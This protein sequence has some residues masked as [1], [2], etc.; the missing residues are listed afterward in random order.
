MKIRYSKKQFLFNGLLGGTF[1]L[2]SLIQLFRKEESFSAHHV[3][4]GIQFLLGFT[5]V[6]L[7]FFQRKFQYLNIENG[8][9]TKN[10]LR[11]KSILLNEIIQI[12][13]F[14]GKIKLFTSEAKEFSINTELIS[15][16]SRHDLLKVLGSL[17]VENNP[18]LG[19]SPRTS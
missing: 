2:A 19:Y 6:I 8:I 11:K 18:F 12:K 13:S 3:I 9:L 1:L 5:M 10:N 4:Y 17:K 14:P 15:D 7:Y 16:D